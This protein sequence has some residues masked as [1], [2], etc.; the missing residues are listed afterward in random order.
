MAEKKAKAGLVTKPVQKV[1]ALR[2][3]LVDIKKNASD[4]TQ[5][6]TCFKTL[7]LYWGTSPRRPRRKSSG[8]LNSQRRVSETRRRRRR[9]RA[10]LE[11]TSLSTP[12][13]A[14]GTLTLPFLDGSLVLRNSRARPRRRRHEPV[15]RRAV[16]HAL[17]GAAFDPRVP[18][19]TSTAWA[20]FV[21]YLA[22]LRRTIEHLRSPRSSLPA[23]RH[24]C[25]RSSR[26]FVPSCSRSATTTPDRAA[27]LGS[28]LPPRARRRK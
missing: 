24:G 21:V 10:F 4:A 3:V 7:L 12:D 11:T 2:R 8:S 19:R 14:A 17:R 16:I 6:S 13:E 9:R 1:D 23:A 15:L 18:F 20:L 26:P 27:P 22:T 25:V 28:A 5:S